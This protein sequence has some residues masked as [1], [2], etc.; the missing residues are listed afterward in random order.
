MC[1]Q[2]PLIVLKIEDSEFWLMWVLSI[3]AI[4]E[5]KIET[6]KNIYSL[7]T[8]ANPLHVNITFL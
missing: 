7:K 6:V 4:F 8:I 3:V 1:C 2:D 5:I